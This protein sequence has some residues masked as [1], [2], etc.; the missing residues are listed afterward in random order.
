MQ[1]PPKQI[2]VVLK[3]DVCLQIESLLL[4]SLISALWLCDKQV[5]DIYVELNKMKSEVVRV[6]K[7][8]SVV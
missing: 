7:D 1:R 6:S 8:I 4:S 2:G 5:A 3:P